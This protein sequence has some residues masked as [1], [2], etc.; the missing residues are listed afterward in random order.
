MI[1]EDDQHSVIQDKHN[2]SF[3]TNIINFHGDKSFI[4]NSLQKIKNNTI[5]KI[6]RKVINKLIKDY[7]RHLNQYIENEDINAKPDNYELSPAYAKQSYHKVLK[8]DE[9][10]QKLF[11]ILND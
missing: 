4:L 8:E 7:T 11:S 10:L 1:F 6:K 2:L 9:Y 3:V 5:C